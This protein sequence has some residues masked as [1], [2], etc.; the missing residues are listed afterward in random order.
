MDELQNIPEQQGYTAAATPA[1]G[2]DGYQEE[3]AID[4]GSWAAAEYGQQ[5][6]YDGYEQQAVY[7]GYEQQ[8]VYPGY[9]QQ[10]VYPGYEQ[11]VDYAGQQLGYETPAAQINP[12]PKT[13]IVVTEMESFGT[14]ANAR[15]RCLVRA[16]SVVA[17]VAVLAT[18]AVIILVL[19]PR[20]SELGDDPRGPAGS[21]PIVVEDD[22]RDRTA[23]AAVVPVK[24]A[25]TTT[26]ATP[27][28]PGIVVCVSED[29][30]P[31]TMTWKD[32]MAIPLPKGLCDYVFYTL[33]SESTNIFQKDYGKSHTF[34]KFSSYVEKRS[35]LSLGIHIP[36]FHVRD[37]NSNLQTM[38]GKEAFK[39]YWNKGFKN[40]AVLDL[41][42]TPL[43]VNADFRHVKT[44]IRTIRSMKS[45]KMY[46]I[47]G[48]SILPSD[49]KNLSHLP[50]EVFTSLI[51]ATK[52]TGVLFRTTYRKLHQGSECTPTG[53]SVYDVNNRT[54]LPKDQPIFVNALEFMKTVNL[55][56]VTRR[57]LS[58]SAAGLRISPNGP[59][60]YCNKTERMAP[61]E[62]YCPDG[63]FRAE[64]NPD[65]H[66]DP[67]EPEVVAEI[68]GR[69]HTY[70][71]DW[72][73]TMLVKLC[74]AN[75]DYDFQDSVVIFDFGFDIKNTCW[76]PQ[77]DRVHGFGSIFDVRNTVHKWITCRTPDPYIRI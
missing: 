75:V 19:F 35:D 14:A 65:E 2:Y 15:D 6:G 61:P 7:P 76:G 58:L 49:K 37:T 11:Q 24:R 46:I 30:R 38:P 8:A 60:G 72:G 23:P 25:T 55:P 64:Y 48:I 4:S 44:L 29:L 33:D 18:V 77:Q 40:F 74:Y 71:Y 52:P 41:E 53:S 10:V 1:Y 3:P 54:R 36:Q 68:Q 47:I 42:L 31:P 57:F 34:D 32:F 9:E 28:L 13:P 43:S 20:S 16:V 70:I 50:R 51:S 26:A 17:G 21:P 59:D 67:K 22:V 5:A 69:A 56:S 66:P 73:Q 45:D 12:P 39:E 27:T 62:L 63:R